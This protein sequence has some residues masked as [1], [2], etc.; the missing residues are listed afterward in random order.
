MYVDDHN[1][2]CSA[3]ELSLLR[4]VLSFVNDRD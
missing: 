4:F 1:A 3:F 2:L